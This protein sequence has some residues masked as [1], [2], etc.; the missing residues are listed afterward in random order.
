MYLYWYRLCLD[1]LHSV[2]CFFLRVPSEEWKQKISAAESERDE[3]RK[4][5]Q[6]KEKENSR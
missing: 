6:E 5:R 3:E 2:Q 4:H 1:V